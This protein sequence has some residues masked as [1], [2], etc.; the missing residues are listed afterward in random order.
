MRSFLSGNESIA[1][2]SYEAGVRYASS[3]PGTP[4]TEILETLSRFPEVETE[5]AVN[6]KVAL[7]CVIGASLSGLR[8]LYASKHVGLNVAAD[9][10]MTLS[11]T[12]VNGGLLIVSADD[13]SMH[14]S[15]N[16]QDNRW[17]ALSAKI[18][19]FEPSDSQE[20]YELTKLL[21]DLSEKFD[22]PTL[23]R[24]TTRLSHS[25][26][27]VNIEGKRTEF[28]RLY[29]KDP[30]KYAAIPAYARKMKIRMMER[31]D[32]LRELSDNFSYNKIELRSK[33]LGIV[34]SG[35][36]YNYV[37]EAFKDASVLKI[38]MSFPLPWK[39]IEQFCRSVDKVYVVEEVDPFIGEQIKAM[40]LNIQTISGSF[41]MSVEKLKKEI[42]NEEIPKSIDVPVRPPVLCP[43]C[44]HRGVFY[45]LHKLKLTVLGDIGCYSLAV[46]PPLCSMDFILCMG[47]G[48]NALH[49][50]SKLNNKK[51]VAV[52]GDSTFY[53]SGITGVL[54]SVY[55]K[56][57]GT[58]IILDN[59]TTA[60]TGHQPHPGTG[61]NAK[62]GKTQKIPIE[63][64]VEACGV[65][66]IRIVN[67][68]DLEEL[69][70]TI[71]EEIE[72][73]EFSVIIAR[74]PC[75]LM[76]EKKE[77]LHINPEKCTGCNVCLSLDCPAIQKNGDKAGIISSLCN[78][79]T[80]CKQICPFGAIE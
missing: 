67:P 24:T 64:I 16:E 59:M 46:L 22:T 20:A 53:H 23:L 18:P 27:V 77:P 68:F 5:W 49:T 13:P 15:Q 42:L 14:S 73:D 12:G 39:K 38:T 48:I 57:T 76:V 8:S 47:A 72:R 10:L 43:G 62:G 63:N 78:G 70:E 25:K 36:S 6:E 30:Q 19:L 45:I 69:K 79:C 29:K 50:F 11:Y 35:V 65:E 75:A 32:K 33:K 34:T 54:N 4:S 74:A 26:C 44:P 58:I 71:S 51:A 40:G 31:L 28:K 3:Y 21:F 41:E 60:M 37:R 17:Y 9:P 2:G 55:N 80:L 1:H 7:E 52:I 66:H 56:G 61:R